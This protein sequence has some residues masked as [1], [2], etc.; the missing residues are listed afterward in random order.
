MRIFTNKIPRSW[1]S[2]GVTVKNDQL[3]MSSF[4]FLEEYFISKS[5]KFNITI[6]GKSLMGNGL[7]SIAV[8]KGSYLVWQ[9]D[10]TFDGIS[11]SK[12]QIQIEESPEESFKIT[13][14]RGKRSK[15]KLVINQVFIYQD[16]KKEIAKEIAIISDIDSEH[17][18]DEPTF[19]LEDI[20]T[21][22]STITEEKTENLN[23]SIIE[24]T[25]L[26][27]SSQKEVLPPKKQKRKAR[28][29]R[30]SP[31]VTDSL[32]N[33]PIE[34]TE[35]V[36]ADPL[37]EKEDIIEKPPKRAVKDIWITVID[38]DSADNERDIFNYLNQISFGREK[39]TF[40]VKQSSTEPIDFSKYDHVKVFFNDQ[41]IVDALIFEWPRKI[42]S[43]KENLS[44]DLSS[45][46]EEIKNEISK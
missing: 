42:T 8:Y 40:F 41:D 22:S 36:L 15:G 17:E 9:E 38:F 25:V 43:L 34:K 45:K 28:Y 29:I 16:I 11:F 37:L 19:F 35:V 44:Q 20:S 6:I 27:E 14:S 26:I 10:L 2:S 12:K 7:C 24:P 3:E 1:K 4:S 30:V 39:Q 31:I 5:R 46:I 33:N 32:A 13:I 23:H 21:K 18:E